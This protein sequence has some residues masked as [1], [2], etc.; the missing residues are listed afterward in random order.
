MRTLT[1]FPDEDPDGEA[2]ATF[3]DASAP[4]G[5]DGEEALKLEDR[6]LMAISSTL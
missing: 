1:R 6:G 4:P 5:A 2:A 3:V